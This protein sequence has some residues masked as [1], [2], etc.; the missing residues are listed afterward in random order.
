MNDRKKEQIKIAGILHDI[1]L[2]DDLIAVM[3]SLDEKEI[4]QLY[5]S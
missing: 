4:K 5:Q 2:D 1:G 3:T